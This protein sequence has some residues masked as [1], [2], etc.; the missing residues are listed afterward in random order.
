MLDFGVSPVFQPPIDRY[1]AFKLYFIILSCSLLSFAA[2][3][4]LFQGYPMR[5]VS[6]YRRLF[7]I[8][9]I[10]LFSCRESEELIREKFK[11]LKGRDEVTFVIFGDSVSGGRSY[12]VTGTSYGSFMKPMVEELLDSRVSMIN[13]CEM[14][15]TFKTSIRRVQEDILS[16]K[17][18]IVLLMLGL[19]DSLQRGLIQPVFKNQ[20]DD[21]LKLLQERSLF[22]IVLTPVGYRDI[23]GKDDPRYQR[24]K[25]FDDIIAYSSAYH[26]FPLIDVR[27]HM[28][29]IL[30]SDPGEYK[31]MFS[32]PIHLSEK[33]HK[34]VADFI[35]ERVTTALN[36]N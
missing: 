35:M 28:E 36:R 26:H 17:P 24:L 15:R 6:G 33:G 9:I 27:V 14:G 10:F 12:S 23:K 30:K 31:T 20:V 16:F 13:S 4:F 25:E 18:D 5:T 11:A 21:L 34:A 7:F 8:G 29:N 19:E 3:R 32:D 2:V 1:Y 22:V